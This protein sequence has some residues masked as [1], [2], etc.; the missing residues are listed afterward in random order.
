R[1]R[2]SPVDNE[3]PRPGC[4]R[5]ASRGRT[6]DGP[7]SRTSWRARRRAARGLVERRL[8]IVPLDAYASREGSSHRVAAFRQDRE[9]H[10]PDEPRGG[11]TRP[12]PSTTD[13]YRGEL[14]AP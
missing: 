11:L 6:G 4:V 14:S 13:A 10:S 3:P 12:P 2:G 7:W 5:L 9:G 8:R 1:A